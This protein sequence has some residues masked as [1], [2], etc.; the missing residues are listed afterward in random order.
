MKRLNFSKPVTRRLTPGSND[1][2]NHNTNPTR[3]TGDFTCFGTYIYLQQIIIGLR[4]IYNIYVIFWIL[5]L[6]ASLISFAVA[7]RGRAEG[8]SR[9]GRHFRRGGTSQKML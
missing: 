9:P 3:I 5:H 4:K 8:A 6:L 1:Y 2:T 7:Y